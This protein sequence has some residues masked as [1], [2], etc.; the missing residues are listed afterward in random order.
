MFGNEL[1]L[2]KLIFDIEDR[3]SVLPKENDLYEYHCYWNICNLIV[4]GEYHQALS[5][6]FAYIPLSHSNLENRLNFLWLHFQ[7]ACLVGNN[8]SQLHVSKMLIQISPFGD[9]RRLHVLCYSSRTR[10][11]AAYPI[12]MYC[13][14]KHNS[15]PLPPHLEIEFIYNLLYRNKKVEATNRLSRFKYKQ[16]CD[17][18]LLVSQLYIYNA[19]KLKAKDCLVSGLNQFAHR[20]DFAYQVVEILF[21]QQSGDLCIPALK[22]VLPY[23]QSGFTASRLLERSAQAMILQRKYALALRTKLIERLPIISG[24]I[25][26]S[27]ST[28][29]NA[30]N[31]LGRVNWLEHIS[32]K[33][34]KN[35]ELYPDIFENLLMYLSSRASDQYSEL[36]LTYSSFLENRVKIHLPAFKRLLSIDRPLCPDRNLRIGWICGDITQHPVAR[37][38]YSWLSSLNSGHV[39]HQHFVISTFKPLTAYVDLFTSLEYVQFLD[40][41]DCSN[42]DQYVSELRLLD[43]DIAIDLNGWTGNNIMSAFVARVAPIQINYLAYH[44]SS[45]ISQMDYWLIDNELIPG[46]SGTG[47]SDEWHTETLLRLDRPFI[48]WQPPSALPEGQLIVTEFYGSPESSIHFGCFNNTRKISLETLH[49]WSFILR[50][51]PTS[52]LVLKAFESDDADTSTLL[53]RRLVDSGISLDQIIFLPYSP[54]PSEHLMQ[55]SKIDVALDCHPNSGCTTTC[56]ALWMG[57]PVITLTGSHYVSRMSHSILSGIGLYNWISYSNSEYIQKA[58]NQSN[59]DQLTWLRHNRSFWRHALQS[60]KLGDA[61]DLMHHLNAKFVQLYSKYVQDSLL[62]A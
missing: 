46:N 49:T 59:P 14:L 34:R 26:T 4:R 20:F 35:P 15:M 36:V 8:S 2:S 21:E 32:S 7:L 27:I 42:I 47:Q 18:C 11:S 38:L 23:H 58:I 41:S 10:K 5:R 44:A 28:L 3:S 19:D 52:R 29:I 61:S 25:V 53:R 57:V 37:F 30:Y 40:I 33:Y 60:S 17:Y 13:E 31:F 22:C 62:N 55:Y 45:G 9:W 16:S 1:N 24:G 50:Q 12:D 48:S 6:L 39:Q 43:L 56:E 54:T 51:L